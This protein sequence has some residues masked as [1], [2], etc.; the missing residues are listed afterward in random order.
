MTKTGNLNQ[1]RII[2]RVEADHKIG[3]GHLF[4]MLALASFL[5]TKAFDIL[6]VTRTDQIVREI[7][8]RHGIEFLAYEHSIDEPGVIERTVHTQQEFRPPALWI[9]DTFGTGK[10]W[11]TSLHRLRV[12]VLSFD[13]TGSGAGEA[14]IVINAIAGLWSN[15]K[16]AVPRNRFTGL[17]YMILTPDILRYRKVREIKGN[18]K[19]K[20]GVGLGGSDTYNNTVKIADSL[21]Y[22]DIAPAMVYFFLGPHF[23][24]EE[25]LNEYLKEF[26][27]PFKVEKNIPDLTAAFDNMDA[28]ICGGGITLFEVCALGLPALP[29]ANEPHETQ[30]ITYFEER[31]ACIP[32]GSTSSG[33]EELEEHINSALNDPERLNAAAA[34]G[35]TLVD[36]KGI[37]RVLELIEK[38]VG[39]GTHV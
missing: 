33:R 21:K 25:K 27:F 34:N 3:M 36:G 39:V 35:R 17:D 15:S 6:F 2:I 28:V 4:R 11:Y 23:T 29:L 19:L 14:D 7:L 20:L 5:K 31:G 32:I 12:P 13:D 37:Y 18:P 9:F 8:E 38:Q 10:E 30:T 24:A 26:P 1:A 16:N 22:V